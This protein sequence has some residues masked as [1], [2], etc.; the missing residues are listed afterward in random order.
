MNRNLFKYS[1]RFMAVLMT[2]VMFVSCEK[3]TFTEANALDLELRKLRVQD[4]IASIKESNARK[5]EVAL[6]QYQRQ[7]DSL[8]AIDA[9]GRVF[10]TVIPVDG[11]SAVFA[12]GGRTEGVQGLEDA[13][14]TI[15]Q[16]GK[17]LE[18]TSSKNGV[19]TFGAASGGEGGLY[20]GEVT[21]TVK[22]ADYTTANYVANLTPDG[23][24]ANGKIVYVGNV[25]P[26][27]GEAAGDKMATISGK[28]W[29]ETDL[30]TAA[31]GDAFGNGSEEAAPNGTKIAAYIDTDR[32]GA[33]G[34]SAFWSRYMAE[35]NDEGF[36]VG[37]GT[38][39][40]TGS[41][42]TGST[43]VTKSGYIQRIAYEYTSQLPV[44]SVSNGD[45]SVMVP[46]T[47][48]GLPVK[49]E[50]SEF[51]ADRTF[52][53]NNEVVT[54][55]HLYGP[56]VKADP[57]ALGVDP[58]TVTFQ[59]YTTEATATAEYTP[60]KTV[61]S[62]KLASTTKSYNYF[63]RAPSVTVTGNAATAG[64]L[65]G[66]ANPTTTAALDQFISVGT[67]NANGGSAYTAAAT[68]TVTRT[69][70]ILL[71]T[72][73]QVGGV[74]AG[75]GSIV[76]YIRVING[77]YGF[78]PTA[79]AT[80]S[81]A[82]AFTNKLPRLSF[83]DPAT[84]QEPTTTTQPTA[85]VVVDK[86]VGAI[87]SVVATAGS[88]SGWATAPLVVPVYGAADELGFKNTTLDLQ[89]FTV[90]GTANSVLTFNTADTD[91]AA[92]DVA[93]ARTAAGISTTT[94]NQLDFAGGYGS[95]FV[96]VPTASII[97]NNTTVL[98]L[99]GAVLPQIDVTVA[100][101]ET[102]AATLGRIVKLN[103]TGIFT[104]NSNITSANVE[105]LKIQFSVPTN[106][107]SLSNAPLSGTGIN[108]YSI[109]TGAQSFAGDLIDGGKVA[110]NTT[111]AGVPGGNSGFVT[112]ANWNA[113]VNGNDAVEF[114]TAQGTDAGNYPDSYTV[115]GVKLDKILSVTNY[116]VAF[117]A[118]DD[119]NTA[120]AVKKYA[121]GVPMF[122]Y[123][124]STGLSTIQGVRIL[125]PGE[126]YQ[127]N[128]DYK[129]YLVPNIFQAEAREAG[130]IDMSAENGA[131]SS[132]AKF[133]VNFDVAYHITN[134]WTEAA[135]GITVFSTTFSVPLLKTVTPAQIVY[136]LTNGG[137]GYSQ[138]PV[139]VVYDGG[140][141][142]NAVP[143]AFVPGVDLRSGSVY[144]LTGGTWNSTAKTLTIVDTG[145]LLKDYETVAGEDKNPTVKIIDVLSNALTTKFAS[146]AAW[147]Q[148][149]GKPVIQLTKDGKVSKIDLTVPGT[150][151]KKVWE[152]LPEITYNQMPSVV[153]SA[154]LSGTSN[155][156]AEVD[157]MIFSDGV[158][159][160]GSAKLRR[161]SSIKVTNQ[162]AGYALGNT[163]HNG[164]NVGNN[165]GGQ[166]GNGTLNA[167]QDFK[168]V[169]GNQK[170]GVNGDENVDMETQI[171]FD[172]FSGISYVRDVHYGTGTELE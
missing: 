100:S 7:I 165:Y 131:K 30:T 36:G 79:A 62:D 160:G 43:G 125:N 95:G 25:I 3:D 158:A 59:A 91:I 140:F 18:A 32:K 71:G 8:A 143:A 46:A 149:N 13:T 10:Y 61:T 137:S 147:A 38:T 148:G 49:L 51:A 16:W 37:G 103:M 86:T 114:A 40:V 9:A 47:A 168:V 170:G 97:S 78:I 101:D 27:F 169:G 110:A 99:T 98:N 108:N 2:A 67:A 139:T 134:G 66:I 58:V 11:S 90:S 92:N 151:G 161:I 115:G 141:A 122:D 121:Y 152:N 94:G 53:R 111:A 142:F 124:V 80:V 135:S 75:G 5:H 123:N 93:N 42:N 117:E 113:F 48:S 72:A 33:N 73:K 74:S 4:S 68:A 14:V 26:L 118:P 96:F 44:A 112:D 1:L 164:H 84:N 83:R 31:S 55:R 41:T 70:A 146:E 24:V 105:H 45:Y 167:G 12:T 156:T 120:D 162:G 64:G 171:R 163:Y 153:I 102:N 104:N 132:V 57:I 39:A 20:S 52:Y 107:L 29:A 63:H 138:A 81:T 34:K 154:P 119:A 88:G 129:M 157:G 54:T 133:P 145:D 69:D 89:F 126:G 159:T 166:S 17:A 172:V 85:N 76:G 144:K 127:V 28:A 155:A 130:T 56:N 106:D 150:G 116:L 77:G 50:F 21:V 6:V 15:T 82:G 65:T 128:K 35:G 109:A 23:P 19:Y 60:K 22:R 136:T 87:Q